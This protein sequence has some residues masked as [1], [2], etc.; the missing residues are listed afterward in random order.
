[1]TNDYFFV[2]NAVLVFLTFILYNRD[3]VSY[4][5]FAIS[6]YLCVISRLLLIYF[7]NRKTPGRSKP[8]YDYFIIINNR[9]CSG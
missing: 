8:D 9:L 6:Y 2:T 1:M 3:R 7:N 4:N 5:L